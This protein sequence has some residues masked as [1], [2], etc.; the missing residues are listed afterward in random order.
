MA[1]VPFS[2]MYQDPALITDQLIGMRERMAKAEAEIK[3]RDRIRKA[4]RIRKLT[5]LAK[6]GML[7]GNTNGR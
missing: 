7:K 2:W 3:E 6:A 1:S 5:K 4:R